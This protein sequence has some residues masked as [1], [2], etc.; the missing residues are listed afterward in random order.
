LAAL[1]TGELIA[2]VRPARRAEREMRIRQRQL[3]RCRRGSR[4]RRK[5]KARLASLSAKIARVRATRLHQAT[6]SLAARFSVIAVEKLNIK[7][8]AGGMLAKEVHDASWG[9][10]TQML[11]YK[12]A[13]AGG[14]VVEVDPRFT[15]QICPEC[16]QIAKKTLSERTHS[17]DCGCVLDRDVAAAMV[18]LSRAGNGP[19]ALNVADCGK[20]APRNICEGA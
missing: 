15:S 1:S 14:T 4:R 3:A 7:G 5:V 13:K 20:R 9:R 12:A 10:F 17:C 6:A 18:I 8:L 11:R 19:G 16:G 2:N